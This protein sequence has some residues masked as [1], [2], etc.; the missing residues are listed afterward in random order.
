MNN[1][2]KFEKKLKIKC[3]RSFCGCLSGRPEGQS[4]LEFVLVLPLLIIIVLVISQLGYMIYLKTI[5]EH[6]AE[7]GARVLSTTNSNK[8]VF[9]SID[10]NCSS[11]QKDKLRVEIIP[12]T[13]PRRHVGDFISVN[14]NYGCGGMTDFFDRLTGRR[15]EVEGRC[16]MRMESED[17]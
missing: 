16:I 2:K 10:R 14:L 7:Q 15:T 12:G 1:N 17:A 9:D 11:L 4:S 13:S 6:A 8:D 5:L 3:N